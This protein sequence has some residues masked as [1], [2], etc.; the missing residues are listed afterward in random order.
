[1]VSSAPTF[2]LLSQKKL[3]TPYQAPLPDASRGD[4]E[5]KLKIVTAG[6]YDEEGSKTRYLIAQAILLAW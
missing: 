4:G 1:L 5:D 6:Q 3:T 2:V